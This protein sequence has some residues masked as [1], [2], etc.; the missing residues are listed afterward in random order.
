MQLGMVPAH[1][2]TTSF[3]CGTSGTYQ[4]DDTTH[5]ITGNTSCIGALNIDS[6]VTEIANWAFQNN[7]NLTSVVIPGS[8]TAIG[9]GAFSG[10]YL[11]SL[12]FNEGLLT[13]GWSAFA[14]I[15]LGGNQVDVVLPSSLTTISASAFSQSTFRS[16]SIGENVS[17][18]GSS[19]FYNNFGGG[20]E[21][22]VFRGNSALTSISDTTFTGY[23]G[24]TLD[25]PQNLTTIGNR[26]IEFANVEYLIIPSGVTSIGNSALQYMSNIKTLI[27]SDNLTTMGTNIFVST[28]SID[29]VLYCGSASAVQ[30]YVYP[31]SVHP[32]CAKGVIFRNNGGSGTMQTETGTSTANLTSNTFTKSGSSFNG[33]NTKADGTGTSYANNAPYSFANNLILYAQWSTASVPGAPTI[34]TAAVTSSTSATVTFTSP[35]SDGGATIDYYQCV[36]S[37]TT[38]TVTLNQAGSGTCTFSGLTT[39]TSYQFKVRAHNSTGFSSYSSLSNAVIPSD[40]VPDPEVEK[41]EA[42]RKRQ[43]EIDNCKT[44]LKAAL[45]NNSKIE[46]GT[47]TKCGYRS[48]TNSSEVTVVTKLQ[49]LPVDSRTADSVLTAVVTKIGTYEDLQ[50][51]KAQSVTPRQLVETGIIDSSVPNKTVI[52]LQLRNLEANARDSI[53]KIDAFIALEAKRM[54][55]RKEHLNA[56]IS[57]I[58]TR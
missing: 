55:A 49:N 29:T 43:Q 34:G 52:T 1:A 5:A 31:N 28:T 33:W 18:I 48:L 30:N 35:G 26:A 57:K 32:V 6:S 39:G 50:G 17:S 4:V 2:T 46:A 10:S 24:L 20:P 37:P 16:I 53:A 45:A 8:V 12:V 38:T 36:S 54:Q 15:D 56:I 7:R 58:Q 14:N 41:R 25:L 51:G 21:S 47:F 9:S 42:E 40:N 3:N 27:L 13:I 23:R 44:A 19:A 22:I 11:T